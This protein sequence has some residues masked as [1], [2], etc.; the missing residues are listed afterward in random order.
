MA[1]FFPESKNSS[2]ESKKNSA[3]TTVEKRI[4]SSAEMPRHSTSCACDGGCA[5]CNSKKNMSNKIL[6]TKLHIGTANDIYEQEADR[7][8]DHVLATSTPLEIN[9]APLSIQRVTG[10]S[11]AHTG[12]TIPAS[13]DHVI[14]SNGSPL[15]QP[16]QL[17]MSQRF[18]HDF[19]DVRIHTDTSAEKSAQDLQAKA[20]TVGQKIVF[21]AGQF[22]PGTHAGRHLLA[23]ELTHVVQQRTDASSATSL[24]RQPSGT[25]TA[26]PPHI[27]QIVVD[28]NT[29]QQVTATFS[30]GHTESDTC[31]TGKG[32]CCFDDDA[33]TA[34]GG[35]CSAARST[36]VGNNCTP[37]GD[38]TVTAQVPVTGGGVRLWTQF[39]NAKSVAL[40]EYSPVDGTPLSHGCVRMNTAMAQTI[41]DGTRVGVTR[42]RVQGL[43]RPSCTNT[44]LQNEWSGD[45]SSAGTTP[46]DG[47]TID[48][49]LGRR[50]TPTEVARERN[51]I[52]ESREELRNAYGV[53]DAGLDAE[54]ATV[55]GGASIVS[56]IPRCVPAL[57]T[58]EQQVTAAQTSGFLTAG[59]TT[60]ATAFTTALSAVRSEASAVLLVQQTGEQL[61]QAATTAARAGGSG[62]DDRQL[63]WTRLMLTTA[64]RQWNP[65]WLRISAVNSNV[66]ALRR[67]QTRLLQLLEQSSRGITSTVFPTS[68]PDEKRI[69]ISG[70][71]P[72]GFSTGGDIRQSNLSGAATLALDGETLTQGSVTAH[73]EGVIFPVRYSDFNDGIVENS[74]RPHLTGSLPPH[75]VMSISQGGSQFELE[76]TAG[77]RRSAGSFLDNLNRP[78]GTET[79]PTIPPGSPALATSPEFLPHSVPTAM[80]GAMRGA[81]G[82]ST[83]IPEETT[84]KDLPLGATQP[85]TL[86]AGP[87]TNPGIAVEGSG[88]GFL[89]NEIFYRNS[90]LRTQLGS[91]VPM[92]HL[93][94]PRLPP[95]ATDAVRNNF[96]DRTRAILRAAVPNL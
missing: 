41:Y 83:A 37:V 36:Q 20:Y 25:R 15:E 30:D 87:G 65:S 29:P 1:A 90:L 71:D 38:F 85:R 55:Q 64:L 40:H 70:F 96:I 74:L 34:E 50:L 58:E 18:G 78:S 82:R 47:T 22:A 57:T 77:R 49:F 56:R 5:R 93:H 12:E 59:A 44:N 7:T 46:P 88:G 66:D 28:Q 51:H 42:V 68:N 23:H 63:Y 43:A 17:D 60:T 48:P 86:P 10:Q 81:E 26:R 27:T 80:L 92:I 73:V 69:L 61:W 79:N 53:N 95:G 76:E 39:H 91:T 4:V 3:K 16:L 94:T 31:S 14:S 8:A 75:L 72:F 9:A 13:V 2:A 89:S 35:A 62:S 45:F 21:G 24:Q 52:R 33:G 84:V 19:S 11:N 54:L 67:L 32:H 6:Q